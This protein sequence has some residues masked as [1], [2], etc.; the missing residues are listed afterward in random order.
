MDE[1]SILLGTAAS[2]GFV[3]TVLGIDHSLPFVALGRAQRWTLRKTLA[4]T[5]ACGVAHVLSSVVIGAVG[6]GAGVALERM[7][8]IESARGDL[9]AWLLITFGLTYA[10]WAVVRRI[11][12]V[13]HHHAHAHLDGTLHDH[14]HDH[15]R[16][17]L[18][19]H[20]EARKRAVTF[21]S[22]FL[23]FAFGPCEALIPVLMA[24]AWTQSWALAGAV[25]GV[26][27]LVTLTTMLATVTVVWR[28]LNLAAIRTFRVE[29][30]ADSLAGLLVAAS[31]GL[32]LLG[33]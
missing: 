20:A 4:V 16:E 15:R 25:V 12:G 5:A 21:W 23:I 29:R 31:G 17:H 27:G 30:W 9:V 10:A 32:I 22:L 13:E 24:P 6:I 33:L 14:D 19:A 18:H 2:I 26:F 3:H 7:E 1:G 28:G 11:R 8:L